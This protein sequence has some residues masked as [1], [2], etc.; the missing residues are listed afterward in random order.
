MKLLQKLLL[1]AVITLSLTGQGYS[2]DAGPAAAAAGPDFF[3]TVPDKVLEQVIQTTLTQAANGDPTL[4]Q[5]GSTFYHLRV[6]CHRFRVMFSNS[7]KG[8]DLLVRAL[9]NA[10]I[11]PNEALFEI[12]THGHHPWL[13]PMLVKIG[14]NVNTQSKNGWTP[15]HYTALNGHLLVALEL[16]RARANVNA[17]NNDGNTPLN[18]A[19]LN[20]HLSI[21]KALLHTSANVNTQDHN[22]W[23]PL[24]SAT[25]FGHLPVI[26]ELI[27]LDANVNTQ[28]NDGET[29]L[30]IAARHG[31]ISVAQELIRLGANVNTQDNDQHAPLYYAAKYRN[32][33]VAKAL[34]DAG[35]HE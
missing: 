13:I 9:R 17:Q 26:Q 14:A 28:N 10:S 18:L 11:N 23:T 24:H 1:S 33:K 2:M 27:R 5:F 12:A 25:I 30:H 7:A 6:K 4:R 19:A 32:L 22:G 16:I 15:L 34:S 31:H 35:A 8:D 3:E 20:G 29:P 21:V